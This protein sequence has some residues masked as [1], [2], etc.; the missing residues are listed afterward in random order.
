MTASS[1]SYSVELA[2]GLSLTGQELIM[3]VSL[4]VFGFIILS[5]GVKWL[6]IKR[7]KNSSIHYE[8]NA[9]K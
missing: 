7:K 1:L 3:T 8:K 2:K 6:L 9:E 4:A 5:I